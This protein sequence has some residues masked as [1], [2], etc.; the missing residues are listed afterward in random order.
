MSLLTAGLRLDTFL[1]APAPD[2][3]PNLTSAAH[4]PAIY[5]IK[6]T[7]PDPDVSHETSTASP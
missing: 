3:F 5:I 7:K 2:L 1:E 6:A 4:L